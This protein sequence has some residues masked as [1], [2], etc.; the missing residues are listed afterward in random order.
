M[1]TK[2]IK[3]EKLMEI[4][5]GS[6]DGGAAMSNKDVNAKAVRRHCKVKEWP[7]NI[8]TQEVD[9]G[10]RDG[11]R[12]PTW[13]LIPMIQNEVRVLFKR[14]YGLEFRH[15]ICV[16][17][18]SKRGK[19]N[20]LDQSEDVKY[21]D[22]AKQDELMETCAMVGS[23]PVHPS[24][25]GFQYA[26]DIVMIVVYLVS[27][28]LNLNVFISLFLNASTCHAGVIWI[29]GL[30]RVTFREF[31][32]IEKSQAE[33][34]LRELSRG[35]SGRPEQFSIVRFHSYML[36][37]IEESLEQSR[38]NYSWFQ[39]LEN[40][41]ACRVSKVDPVMKEL[42]QSVLVEAGMDMMP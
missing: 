20:T 32:K 1:G 21:S 33:S 12:G 36:F 8:E 39:D 15:A 3:Q 16:D 19:E 25:S 4:C 7:G 22:A 29:Y 40:L 37:F 18:T 28:M 6:R 2:N 24:L 30:G 42:P 31:F 11:G 41:V 34:V 38:T 9:F 14:A 13:V 27:F 17:S 10:S 26:L 23:D 35:G 5:N